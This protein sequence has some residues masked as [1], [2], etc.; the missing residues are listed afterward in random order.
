MAFSLG[1]RFR[2]FGICIAALL[3]SWVDA[4]SQVLGVGV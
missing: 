3:W 1:F 2:F 4:Y